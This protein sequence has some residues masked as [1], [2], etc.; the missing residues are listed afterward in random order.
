VSV[1]R[2]NV[3]YKGHNLVGVT[4]GRRRN[5][6]Y[7]STGFI[8][9]Y[10]EAYIDTVLYRVIGVHPTDLTVDQGCR[11]VSTLSTTKNNK[12][13]FFEENMYGNE[14]LVI[15]YCVLNVTVPQQV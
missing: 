12:E 11:Q 14:L 13:T 5:K 3:Q 15:R 9:S 7:D 1:Q 8:D 6:R 2:Y 4:T 10:I